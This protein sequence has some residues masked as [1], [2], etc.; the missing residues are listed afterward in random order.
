MYGVVFVRTRQFTSQSSEVARVKRDSNEIRLCPQLGGEGKF[1]SMLCRGPKKRVFAAATGQPVGLEKSLWPVLEDVGRRNDSNELVQTIDGRL[2]G[3]R[4][5]AF[6]DIGFF[7]ETRVLD[8]AFS[9]PRANE[10]SDGTEKIH[11]LDLR[12]LVILHGVGGARRFL[13]LESWFANRWLLQLATGHSLTACKETQR[14]KW[15]VQR[16]L[17][18]V[19]TNSVLVLYEAVVSGS[20]C[21]LFQ[22]EQL[23]QNE[24]RV[25][26]VKVLRDTK[27]CSHQ[28]IAPPGTG[29][30]SAPTLSWQKLSQNQMESTAH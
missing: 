17:Y 29:K 1:V 15:I 8:R 23:V 12:T 24:L 30:P 6:I 11:E 20:G 18:S 7:K 25:P 27:L 9:G 19:Q 22:P 5:G 14:E 3:V 13:L 21:K 10:T 26:L 4:T 28:I 2:T 16:V